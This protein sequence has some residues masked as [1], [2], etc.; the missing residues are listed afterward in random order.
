M[1]HLFG[2]CQQF[3]SIYEPC[4]EK[5]LFAYAKTKPQISCGCTARFVSDQVGNSE[6]RFSH[7]TAYTNSLV[8]P[9]LLTYCTFLPSIIVLMRSCLISVFPI[10]RYFNIICTTSSSQQP[11]QHCILGN[12]SC[13]Y[14]L[15]NF[16][17]IKFL[18]KFFQEYH[19]N[20]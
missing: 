9:T 16:F 19:Q 6:D 10:T 15:L 3:S 12:S 4:H 20:V 7:D 2:D 8:Y 13:F 17:K 11:T 1:I 5:R 18:K 14:R